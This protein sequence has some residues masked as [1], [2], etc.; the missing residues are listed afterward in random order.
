MVSLNQQLQQWIRLEG[1]GL[2]C[3]C[4]LRA[5]ASPSWPLSLCR[6][7]FGISL[8]IRCSRR[9]L[10]SQLS[11]RQCMRE[12]E[13]ELYRAA[14]LICFPPISLSIMYIYWPHTRNASA[15][16]ITRPRRKISVKGGCYTTAHK[17][18][19]SPALLR[20]TISEST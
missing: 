18:P 2:D 1:D 7:L 12:R 19:T 20:K 13:R 5:R 16:F 14:F 17:S 6:P 11:S 9:L 3:G 4:E 8:F 10:F 15:C